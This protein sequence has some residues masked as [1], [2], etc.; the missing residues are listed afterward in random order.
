MRF[1]HQR[2]HGRVD[3]KVL[4]DEGDITDE[5]IRGA[6]VL[7]ESDCPSH[8]EIECRAFDIRFRSA[9]LSRPASH[10]SGALQRTRPVPMM[11]Q[12]LNPLLQ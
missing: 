12:D 5:A 2:L 9:C 8:V 3:E 7:C 4:W 1:V 10:G 11:S 6:W